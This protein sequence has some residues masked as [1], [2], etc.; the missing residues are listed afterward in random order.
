MMAKSD[1]RAAAI[2][3]LLLG[4]GLAACGTSDQGSPAPDAAEQ[5]AAGTQR[6]DETLMQEG[7]Q[8]LHESGRP[9]AAEALFREV[10]ARTPSHYG[11]HYQLAVALDRSARPSEARAVWSDVLSRAEAI[12][13]EQTAEAARSRLA[14]PDTASQAALMAKG[15]HLLYDRNDPTNAA[16]EF[17]AVLDRSPEHYGATY[18]LATA[19]DRAGRIGEARPL[20]ERVLAMAERYNDEATATAARDRLR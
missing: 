1:S 8:L 15:L 10:I 7:I 2:F 16:T 11:A 14:A 20:W 5:R 13:D 4:A 9:F 17:R 3:L 19:L 6:T 12:A 18:Q